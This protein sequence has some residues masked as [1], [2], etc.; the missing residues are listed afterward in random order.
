MATPINSTKAAA[1]IEQIIPSRRCSRQNL[2]KLCADGALKQSPCIL[3]RSPWRLDAETVVAE[4]L[5]NVSPVQSEAHQPRALRPVTD[6]IA[7]PPAESPPS[8][9][10]DDG[11]VPNFNEERARYQQ[12]KRKLAELTRLEREGQLLRREDVMTAIGAAVNKTRTKIL[13]VPSRVK[14]RIPHLSPEEIEIMRDLLTEALEEL[15]G[16]DAA[17]RVAP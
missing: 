2:E 9:P 17:V 12:E 6:R 4:Y 11:E 13:G 14:Q 16:M 5:A 8:R 15:A 10:P 1:L 3:G 7:K